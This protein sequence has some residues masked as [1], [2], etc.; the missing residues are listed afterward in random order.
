MQTIEQLIERMWEI[1]ETRCELS[2][3]DKALGG[4]Y[5]ALEAALLETMD[6]T[7]IQAVRTNKALASISNTEITAVDD[8]DAF[9]KYIRENDAF[10]LLQKRPAV[11]ACKEINTLTGTPVPGTHSLSVQKVN[12]TKNKGS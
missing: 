8:W 6:A 1:R 12:L 4:E 5:I 3:Q 9:Y 7:G 11:S 2:Q 10:Y